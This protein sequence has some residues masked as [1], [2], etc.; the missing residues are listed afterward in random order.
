[1]VG[2]ALRNSTGM[3]RTGSEVGSKSGSKWRPRRVLPG[4]QIA[5]LADP[6]AYRRDSR[7]DQLLQEDC[8]SVLRFLAEDVGKEFDAVLDII[9]S[10]S[11]ARRP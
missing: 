3:K 9:G 5:H 4:P 10:L 7:R 8:Y 6:V 1:M 11:H 2:C